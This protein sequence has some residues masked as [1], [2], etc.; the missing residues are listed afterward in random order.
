MATADRKK[1][2]APLPAEITTDEAA[3]LVGI[4]PRCIRFAIAKGAIAA[5][6]MGKSYLVE[7]ESAR[8]YAKS[9]AE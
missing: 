7:T 4:S 1:P 6:R 2:R 8:A 9:R 5:R 3:A